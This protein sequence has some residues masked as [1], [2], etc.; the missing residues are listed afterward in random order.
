MTQSS[1]S[2]AQ[3]IE[4]LAQVTPFEKLG[5][6]ALEKLASQCELLRYRMGQPILERDKMPA[7]VAVIYEG[8]AR[9]L[10]NDQRVQSL[11]SLQKIGPGTAIGWASLLRGIACE[12]AIASTE[13]I[14]ICIPAFEFL[15]ILDREA[16][17]SQYVRSLGDISEVFELWSLE[18]KRRPEDTIN[19]KDSMAQ[20]LA[21]TVVV[22]VPAG[23]IDVNLLDT[24]LVWLVSSGSIEDFPVG[25]RLVFDG[26]PLIVQGFKGAR[27]IG[28]PEPKVHTII[29]NQN[30]IPDSPTPDFPSTS[31]VGEIPPETGVNVPTVI[32]TNVTA[33]TVKNAPDRPP[34]AL[35][36]PKGGPV[37]YPFIRGYGRIDA[38]LACFQMLAKHLGINYRKDIIRKVL[39]NQIKTSGQ[40]TLYTCGAIAT[41]MGL[42]AQLVSVNN[43]I[44]IPRLKAPVIIQ[45]R[46][47]KDLET[48]DNNA[49]VSFAILFSINEREIVVGIPEEGIRHFTPEKFRERWGEQGQVLLV[50]PRIGEEKE[51]FS[52]WWFV[53]ALLE[54]RKVIIEVFIASFFVQMFGLA[55]PLITQVIIDKVLGQRSLDT[56]DALGVLMLVVALF[57]GVLNTLRTL[58]FVDATNRID[59]KLGS[60]VIDHLLR[61]PLNY[62]DRRRVGDMIGRV[63]E[64]GNIRGFLTGTALTVVLDAVFSLI[65]I[66]VMLSYSLILTVVALG[67]VPFFAVL[68]IIVTPI[69]RKLLLQRAER[70]ADA[71]SYLVEV[72][73]G[74]QTVKA[75]TIELKSRWRWYERYARFMKSSFKTT[76]ISTIAGTFGSFLNTLSSLALLWVGAHLVIKNEL[77]L[78]QLIAFRI[79]SGNVTGSLLRFV[80]VWQSFQEVGMS[81]ERLRDVMESEPEADEED[82][83]NIPMPDIQGT[84]KFD[85]LSFCF[86]GSPTLQLANVDLEFPAG[87]FVG[88][89]GQSGSGKSTLMKLL[90]RLYDPTQGRIQI[91]GYDISKV[92]LYSL[93]G[94]MGMVLQD[95]LLFNGT[96]QE[97]IALNKPDATTDEII[98]AAKIAVAHDFIMGLPQG[99][100]TNVGER[101]STLSGGQRQR[102]AIARTVLQNPNL[103]ILDE[104]TSALD[105]NS[106]RQVCENLAVAF[107]GRTVF[108][109]T[110]RLPTVRNADVIILMDQGV[111]A[112]KGTHDEL[113]KMRGRYYA[114]YQQQEAQS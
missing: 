98:E 52:F 40:V 70:Y 12:T 6:T 18:L 41:M 21:N 110:H 7:Y 1:L 54:H 104:A 72:V 83:N 46:K 25:S 24:D 56:L 44:A 22:N 38:P 29:T 36:D 51:K 88:I 84:V 66:G 113:I 61:L 67:S 85:K 5:K 53:P 96:V 39:D 59:L 108:F 9:L 64:L 69:V 60:Q 68:M 2:Q 77:T 89:V 33:I 43:A 103:L 15:D 114:L 79:I 19:L 26:L 55:N 71:Q 109:I 82:R 93:R 48:E 57:E 31:P 14:C 62:F 73:S 74:I 99:Y 106:E 65:Y 102:L 16:D 42:N 58:S 76:Q 75:Q 81:I 111:V 92:E 63:N 4:F 27:L 97:N 47:D 78:G 80:Q 13:S 86:L 50:E 8:Q 105:Y 91:D 28:T 107:A 11:V 95:T 23:R 100:N 10:G 3:I 37:K 20:L 112:E 87:T 34:A 30:V 101:G 32:P 94:Q 45:W 17:F 90:Q 35:L 49:T